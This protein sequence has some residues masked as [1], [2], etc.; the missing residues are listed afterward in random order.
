M[1]RRF[2]GSVRARRIGATLLA[3]FVAG[4]LVAITYWRFEDLGSERSRVVLAVVW[5]VGILALVLLVRA[6]RTR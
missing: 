4:Y 2:R 5:G 1:N 6:W 3:F